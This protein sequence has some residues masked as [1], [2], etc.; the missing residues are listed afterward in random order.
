MKDI[1]KIGNLAFAQQSVINCDLKLSHLM[2]LSYINDFVSSGNCEIEIVGAEKYF[3]IAYKK[4]LIDLP[5]LNIGKKQLNNLLLDLMSVGAIIP[6]NRTIGRKKTFF[7]LNLI[8]I[9]HTDCVQPIKQLNIV[10]AS[11]SI[12]ELD[13]LTQ[14]IK[15][16]VDNFPIKKVADR[17]TAILARVKTKPF[18]F[19]D[20]NKIESTVFLSKIINIFSSS[21]NEDCE[22]LEYTFN[23]I[24][25]KKD[26]KNKFLYSVAVLYNL[27]C[28][29]QLVFKV[30]N[31][32][33][34]FTQR[35]YS[36]QDLTSL[37]NSLE[38]INI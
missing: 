11:A 21:M 16:K 18:W 32:S 38:N 13:A 24:D 4:I 23:Y 17:L 9:K 26:I 10:D 36:D 28:D 12:A 25:L 3:Y 1:L 19:V 35:D 33:A 34:N 7:K 14:I 27:A 31:S 30:R 37:F 6:L 5:L 20:K 29:S 2:V 8:P 22:L 15:E